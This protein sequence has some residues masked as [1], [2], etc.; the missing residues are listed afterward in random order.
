ML[1][2]GIGIVLFAALTIGVVFLMEPRSWMAIGYVLLWPPLVSFALVH[3]ATREK[4][5]PLESSRPT[6]EELNR[7]VGDLS[8]GHSE[9]WI[10]G[11]PKL[12]WYWCFLCILVS[13]VCNSVFCIIYRGEPEEEASI[14]TAAACAV[15]DLLLIVFSRFGDISYRF[16]FILFLG[17]IVKVAT[18][19]F[20]H[21]FWYTGHG[22][23]YLFIGTY[24]LVDCL[25]GLWRTTRKLVVYSDTPGTSNSGT[26]DKIVEAIDGFKPERR[27][28]PCRSITASLVCWLILTAGII[29]ETFVLW[30]SVTQETLLFEVDQKDA[31]I[32]L[33]VTSVCISCGIAGACLLYF[34]KGVLGLLSS[35]LNIVG[36]AGFI[37]FTLL[38]KGLEPIDGIRCFASPCYC[39]VA[40]VIGI[41]V[42]LAS[43]TSQLKITFSRI[44]HCE[45][46][47]SGKCIIIFLGFAFAGIIAMIVNPIV[48]MEWKFCGVILITCFI[49]IVLFCAA[50]RIQISEDG[51]LV[52]ASIAL[53]WI[54][55][56]FW[57]G[58]SLSVGFETM[59]AVG[60]GIFVGGFAIALIFYG[61]FWTR[62]NEWNLEIVWLLDITIPSFVLFCV[63][64]VMAVIAET[65]VVFY[66][67][68]LIFGMICWFSVLFYSIKHETLW[69]RILSVAVL[70]VSIGVVIG[71]S[72][73]KVRE[74]F[75]VLTIILWACFITGCGGVFFMAV[76]TDSTNVLVFS[77]I[78]IPVMKYTDG[79][80][81]NM[82]LFTGLYCMIF[83]GPWIWGLFGTVFYVYP[84][85]GALSAS[86]I[87]VLISLLSFAL[88][89]RFDSNALEGLSFIPSE[90]MKGTLERVIENFSLQGENQGSGEKLPFEEQSQWDYQLQKHAS[91]FSLAVKG[92]LFI[93]SEIAFITAIRDITSYLRTKHIEHSF[94]NR[95]F[96]WSS[97][98]RQ[99]IFTIG[100]WVDDANADHRK[101]DEARD[102]Q[103]SEAAEAVQAHLLEL[104]EMDQETERGELIT[105]YKSVGKNLRAMGCSAED[106]NL[107]VLTVEQVKEKIGDRMQQ[108]D[109]GIEDTVKK[110]SEKREQKEMERQERELLLLAIQRQQEQL[111]EERIR[112]EEEME[113][114]RKCEE[115]RMCKQEALRRKAEEE[116][117][118]KG[119][120]EEA[121]QK[122]E[123]EQRR[124]T[125]RLRIEEK[126]RQMLEAQRRLEEEEELE[127]EQ[128]E[129]WHRA[130]EEHR[131]AEHVAREEED[132]ERKRAEELE[133][134]A[135]KRRE[136]DRLRVEEEVR[137]M[138][139]TQ[140][141]QLIQA[142]RHLEE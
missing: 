129:R 3:C 44:I 125:G 5:Q 90:A 128:E 85:F 59:W 19:T 67:I 32:S 23:I 51:E 94:L 11:S 86:A 58:F 60:I 136:V 120:D 124:E 47:G 92:Q 45:L 107:S 56:C 13:L 36:F 16:Q 96:D 114:Q 108:M 65:Y 1:P 80:M 104:L 97:A 134:E 139:E 7:F 42:I 95:V 121:A 38:F 82:T 21:R 66:M 73:W 34:D 37:I 46:D 40:S 49:S 20:T 93:S 141:L 100:K 87:F 52:P 12:P 70:I 132:A 35:I 8:S 115:E 77:N 53:Y 43:S 112:A 6:K 133:A 61:V 68:A 69:L 111:E 106:E 138:Q 76:Q 31:V 57:F 81:H 4:L 30:D 98:E 63:G 116:L 41:A 72:I 142:R 71:I 17:Y 135:E 102:K 10:S 123:E 101:T 122:I 22:F 33:I 64:L 26:R 2:L 55:G 119:R 50:F 88:L 126:R 140:R 83:L 62:F 24:F 28:V 75:L 18:V 110:L 137:Q 79:H 14:G 130:E 117:E 105:I 91:L 127:R 78:F 39:L 48:L 99:T 109:K 84:Q 113:A 15:I 25:I 29:G 89:C 103:N 74:A 27:T 118:Q 9:K 54:S 131:K